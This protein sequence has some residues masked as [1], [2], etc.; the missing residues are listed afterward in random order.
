MNSRERIQL[1]LDHK[2]AD[3]IPVDLGATV[4]TSLHKTAYRNLR[5]HM[6]LPEVDIRLADTVQQLVYVDKDVRDLF[7]VD[8]QGA[9]PQ[10]STI[11]AK[12]QIK[13][14]MPAYTHFYDEWGIGW[15]MP[16]DGGFYFDVFHHPLRGD[17]TNADLDRYPWP[18]PTDPARFV[19][20]RERAQRIIDVD[21]EAVI[22][23]GLCA[24][25][26]EMAG[27]MRGYQDYLIDFAINPS[28]ME[29]LF[30]KLL[31]LKL[32]YWDQMLAEVGDIA[33]AVLESDDMGSQIDM[34]FSPAMYRRLVKP[35]HKLLY[36]FIKS[37]T[38]AKI[39]FHSCGAIR[40]VLPDLIEVGIDILNPVQVSATGMDSADLKRDFGKDLT[41]WG[42]GV[43]TQQVLSRGTV[44]EVKDDVHRRIDDLAP[45]GG[46]VFATIHA[47]QA[48]VPPENVLAVW[49]ALR[50]YDKYQ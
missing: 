16:K 32:A 27:W 20:M 18:D 37:R 5:R 36:D 44:Q 23:G 21:R 45:G 42:G 7:H 14:E 31:E 28:F 3:R 47:I 38:K 41:F 4:M 10:P 24:G 25:F 39:F 33:D 35:R 2:E 48:N 11:S 1:A 30:D 19:G 8:V 15:K 22:I 43:E 40:K 6:R 9:N 13:D 17:L 34:L 49:E 29:C 46:F 26:V 50:Q 12:I